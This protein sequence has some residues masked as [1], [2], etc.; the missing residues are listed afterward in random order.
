MKQVVQIKRFFTTLLI[1]W[2]SMGVAQEI[3]FKKL[4]SPDGGNFGYMIT[5]ITQDYHGNMWF[6]TKQGLY[7]YNGN[8]ITGYQNNP[9]NTNSI[10]SNNLESIFADN[11]GSIWIGTL[12]KGL[13]K[14]DPKTGVFTH[15]QHDPENLGSIS[16]DTITTILRDNLGDLY[17]GTHQG[18]NK[19]NAETNQF[20]HFK[21][22]VQDPKSIS[23]NQVR[24]LHESEDGTIWVGTGSPYADNGGG[25]EDGGFNK[26]DKESETFT[27]YLYDDEDVSTLGNNKISAIYEDDEG[28]L[29]IGTARN[30]I[31]KMNQAKGTFERLTYDPKF[32]ENLG[33]P[34]SDTGISDYEHITFITQDSSGEFWY[35]TVENGIYYFDS[36]QSKIIQHQNSEL[37]VNGFESEGAWSVYNSRDGILWLGGIDQG[38]IFSVNP[39]KI[40]INHVPIEMGVNEFY[41]ASNGDLWIGGDG[42][43]LVKKKNGKIVNRNVK[44]LEPTFEHDNWYSEIQEDKQGNIWVGGFNGLNRWDKDNNEFIQYYNTSDENSIPPNHMVTSFLGDSEDNLWLGTVNGLNYFDTKTAKFSRFFLNKRDTTTVGYNI[45]SKIF[46]DKTSRLWAGMFNGGGLY[47]YDTDLNTGKKYLGSLDINSLYQDQS[48]LL[49]IG[50]SAG[51]FW[52]DEQDDSF[53]KFSNAFLIG[54]ISFVASIQEDD[55]Q[56]LWVGSD[57]GLVQINPD[58]DQ[59]SIFGYDSGLNSYSF[60]WDASYKDSKGR[61]YFGNDEG[62]FLIDPKAINDQMKAPEIRITGFSLADEEITIDPNGP[63]KESLSEAV[64]IKLEHDQNVFSFDF[65]IVDY[66]NPEKNRIIYY[67]ENHDENWSGSNSENRAYYFNI[68]PGNYTFHIKGSN[69]YGPWAEKQIQIIISPPWWKSLWAYVLYVIL[70]ALSIFTFDR[71]MRQRLIRI[72]RERSREKE[73]EQ[74][75]EIEKAYTKLKSTQSQLVQ[76][77][78]MASLGELTAGIAHE[79][80]NPLNFVNNFSE[81]NTELLMEMKEE[82]EKKNYKEVSEIA[83]DVIVNQEKINRHGKRADAIVKGMLQHSRTTSGQKELTD[84]NALTD[85]FLRLAYHGLRAKDKTFNAKMETQF[86]SS[87]GKVNIVAQDVGRVILNLINNA[88]YAVNDRKKQKEEGYEPTVIAATKKFD[89]HL[90]IIITD[91][92]NG[93]PPEIEDKI[94]QPFFTSKPTGEGTGLGLSLSYDIVKAHGGELKV[95]TKRTSPEY[96]ENRDA[97]T[98]FTIILPIGYMN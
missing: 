45:V 54:G 81:V 98:S 55:E 84:I 6:T 58:R 44:D 2:S 86:D 50:S 10:S 49:W 75:K 33:F 35:G 20:T 56:N 28:V 80:Q 77:E 85:E 38:D 32:P 27:R 90:E 8:Q 40:V 66:T 69:G 64:E 19:Y 16:N 76:S 1:L 4:S 18:L 47:L 70:L 53:V 59:I 41:E 91:N 46:M 5:G 72:E 60:H 25:P 3:E 26:F 30:M 92:G 42:H 22:D 12:G 31:H 71:F 62:Y 24:V 48:G 9:L 68:P 89:Q 43:L 34:E 61:L 97:G 52:Y 17:I 96:S 57:V 13:D 94:F 74:A 82:I 78:K 73:L 36:E 65:T 23:N 39:N 37:H 51:L 95:E 87:L 29:W 79:I 67:L 15:F 88:F 14:L 11:D 7:K 21:H 83:D 63:L 93:I